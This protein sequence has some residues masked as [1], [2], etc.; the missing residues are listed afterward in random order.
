[1]GLD[2]ADEYKTWRNAEDPRAAIGADR[3]E[4]AG[5]VA[6]ERLVE[7]ELRRPPSV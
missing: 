5:D 6:F 1:M 7:P 4:A 3:I 2:Y